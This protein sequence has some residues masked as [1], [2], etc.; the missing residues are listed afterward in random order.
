M[1]SCVASHG[2]FDSS[3]R[4]LK[5]LPSV[6]IPS[7]ISEAN[8]QD[9]VLH[10]AG[11]YSN[12]IKYPNAYALVGGKSYYAGNVHLSDITGEDVIFNT[13]ENLERIALNIQLAR[14][15][16]GI[17]TQ[18]NCSQGSTQSQ[19]YEKPLLPLYMR[20]KTPIDL[21]KLGSL[22]FISGI[23]NPCWLEGKSML[24]LPY[25]YLAGFPKCGTTD[26][27][28]KLS[29]HPDFISPFAK[30]PHWLTRSRFMGMFMIQYLRYFSRATAVIG[31][32]YKIGHSRMSS[33]I[34]GDLSASTLWDNDFWPIIPGNS[35]TNIYEPDVTNVDVLLHLNPNVKVIAILRNP[36]TEQD[37]E[38][39]R[40]RIGLY[41]IY[42]SDFLK[43]MPR[44]NTLFLRLEDHAEQPAKT[45]E[46]VFRFLGLETQNTTMQR[47]LEGKV[48]NTRRDSDVSIGSMLPKTRHILNTFYRPF[49][50]K[51]ADLLQDE[52][53]NYGKDT[54]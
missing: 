27:Y 51:L 9:K 16:K 13:S 37:N 54:L 26:I 47:A 5:S 45:M 17:P 50:Q 6:L 20:S 23:K 44:N 21:M 1:N 38:D 34:T 15:D 7:T 8:S 53:F 41:Y 18:K 24:C 48:A 11:Q 14:S 10:S 2:K 33:V 32:L 31:H 28:R 36:H 12:Y 25:F 19:P 49:N 35:H 30:E 4:R 46:T 3:C 43:K 52:K 29:I 39:C 40:L 22:K 42:I